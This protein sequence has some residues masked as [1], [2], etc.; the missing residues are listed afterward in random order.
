MTKIPHSPRALL[1]QLCLQ[2]ETTAGGKRQGFTVFAVNEET[3]CARP[4]LG[5]PRVHPSYT[6]LSKPVLHLPAER[7]LLGGLSQASSPVATGTTCLPFKVVLEYFA[8]A[9]LQT[10]KSQ[11]EVT[12]AFWFTACLGLSS[13]LTGPGPVPR[14]LGTEP[15]GICKVN[16]PNNLYLTRY[17]L[18]GR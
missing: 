8:P 12:L 17:E 10:N 7:T 14:S 1:G 13:W 5:F 18:W 4:S 3:S 11:L 15:C 2:E 6:L 16:F 9:S